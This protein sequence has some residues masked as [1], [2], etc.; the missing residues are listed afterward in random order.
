M[1]EFI[2]MISEFIEKKKCP[3]FD[4]VFLDEAQDLVNKKANG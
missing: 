4:A 1:F 2:D 3:Q